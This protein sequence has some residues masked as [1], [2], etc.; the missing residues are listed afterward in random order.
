MTL[1]LDLDNFTFIYRVM[2]DLSL[3]LNCNGYLKPYQN[4]NIGIN[5]YTFTRKPYP[6]NL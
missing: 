5:N 1:I 2:Q 3:P 4:K 6:Q